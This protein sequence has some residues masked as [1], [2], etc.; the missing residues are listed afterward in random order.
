MI[1]S[2]K[3]RT[4]QI[5]HARVKSGVEA[6]GV[7]DVP[8]ARD[9]IAVRS[10]DA[11]SAL[12][13]KLKRLQA[14]GDDDLVV[15]FFDAFADALKAHRLLIG[16][17]GNADAAADID[18]FELDAGLF[19]DFGHQRKEELRRIDDV[20]GIELVRGDHRMQAKTLD[21]RF[22][23]LR[24]A[25]EK[26][27][28]GEAVLRLLGL[29]DDGVAALQRTWVVAAAHDAVLE[30]GGSGSARRFKKPVPVGDIVEI[31]DRSEFPGL[32]EFLRRGVVGGE[33]D[34]LADVAD[35]LRQDEFR[36]RRT[37]AAK[38]KL[39]QKLHE[40]R[41]GRGLDGEIF[42]EPLVPGERLFKTPRVLADRLGVVDVE[43]SGPLG[44]DFFKF[45]LIK[46]KLSHQFTFL[47]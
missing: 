28:A 31:D 23:H 24:V 46:R 17:I 26:L 18:E 3:R 1:G 9:E 37:V 42:A 35:L 40:I 14:L 34:R 11:A 20:F 39:L 30:I 21:A 43:R 16:T 13:I 5:G 45:C 47:L 44:Y 27:F 7:L 32:A 41:V 25:L 12:H 6:V 15:P 29:A 33:H 22:L 19:G 2:V 36:H 10:G 8:D 38:I 4:H